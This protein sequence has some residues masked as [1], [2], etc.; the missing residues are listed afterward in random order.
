MLCHVP[1]H[2]SYGRTSELRHQPG[3]GSV[4]LRPFYYQQGPRLSLKSKLRVVAVFFWQTGNIAFRHSKSDKYFYIRKQSM[5]HRK[6]IKIS[7]VRPCSWTWKSGI[8][9]SHFHKK[10]I[11]CP[12]TKSSRLVK[13]PGTIHKQQELNHYFCIAL[14][15]FSSHSLGVVGSFLLFSTVI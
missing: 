15:G 5:A 8:H 7:V 4:H 6:C 3:I 12:V 2:P 1:W 9:Q 13:H 14:N 10:R 11:A